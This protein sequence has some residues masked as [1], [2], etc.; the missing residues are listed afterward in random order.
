LQV[1]RPATKD[2]V[3]S[4]LDTNAGSIEVMVA[5]EYWFSGLDGERRMADAMLRHIVPLFQDEDG[6]PVCAGS[7]LLANYRGQHLLVTAAHVLD[8]TMAS[9]VYFYVKPAVKQKLHGVARVHPLSPGQNRDDDLIDVGILPIPADLAPPYTE[10]NKIAF[11]LEHA[12]PGR[13]PRIGRVY[14]MT[15]YPRTKRDVVRPLR[16]LTT[17]P[18]SYVNDSAD[19]QVYSQLGITEETH[20]ALNF[21]RKKAVDGEGKRITVADP[22]GISGSP[23]WELVPSSYGLIS[24]KVLLAT[25]IGIVLAKLNAS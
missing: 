20:I 17:E 12:S 15:G 14:L 19:S 9:E 22:D 6:V 21:H 10:G 13:Y 5:A 7:G 3:W 4:D 8:K 23:L 1:G 25:D 18:I 2:E 11:S 16:Q 24:Q